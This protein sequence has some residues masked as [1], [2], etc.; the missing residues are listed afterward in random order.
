MTRAE[1]LTLLNEHDRDEVIRLPARERPLIRLALATVGQWR[2][3]AGL[4]GGGRI[5]L[6][7]TAVDAVAR[8]L[9][10]LPAP[11]LLDG[12][13]IIETEALRLQEARR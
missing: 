13:T 8:W 12:L 1:A 3:A 4:G 9:G 5:A 7:M 10:I 2:T 6:D 11:D